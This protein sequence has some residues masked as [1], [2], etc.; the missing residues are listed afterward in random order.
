[1]GPVLLVSD[2]QQVIH[3]V[4]GG[5]SLVEENGSTE[6]RAV[7]NMLR[8]PCGSQNVSS[9]ILPFTV[10]S[11]NHLAYILEQK[12]S[13]FGGIKRGRVKVASVHGL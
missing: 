12:S 9:E 10:T 5:Q 6:S 13:R 2:G 11:R 8:L 7:S 3:K 1:M 4:P